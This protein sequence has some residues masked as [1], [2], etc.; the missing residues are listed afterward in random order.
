MMTIR[1]IALAGLGLVALSAPAFA[2]DDICTIQAVTQNGGVVLQGV[3]LSP[4]AL[5]GSYQFEVKAKGP[6]GSSD[7]SQGGMFSAKANDAT[8]LGQVQLS[9]PGATYNV[10]LIIDANGKSY[11]CKQSFQS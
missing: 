7:I 1:S 8:P 6:S 2:S 11:D 3:V 5:S 10:K 9:S 4:A